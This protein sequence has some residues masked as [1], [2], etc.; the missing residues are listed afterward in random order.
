MVNLASQWEKRRA[1]LIDEYRRLKEIC[2]NKDVSCSRSVSCPQ[3]VL[4][5]SSECPQSVLRLLT[6]LVLSQLE[7]NRKLS[8]IKT[9]HEKISVSTEEAKK[10]EELYKQL[11]MSG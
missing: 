8:E 10:K 2:S 11:V 6:H 1:P 3:S 9:L 4:G 5:V 7:S